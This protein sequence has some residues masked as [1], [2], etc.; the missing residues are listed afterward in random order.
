[1]LGVCYYPE[2]WPEARWSVDAAM[3]ADLGIRFVR[4]GEFS[5]SRLEP[6]RDHFDWSWLDR[7]LEA[8]NIA[9]LQVV[10]CTPTATPPKWLVD[11]RPDILAWGS[12]GQAK[13]FGS[14]RHYCFSSVAWRQETARI[15]LQMARRYGDHP[16][17][18]GWQLDNEYGCHDTVLSYAPH[19]R[20]AFQ[21]WLMRRYGVIEGLNKAWGGV[22]WS[23]EYNDFNQVGLPHQTVTEANPSHLLDFRR[24]SSDQVIA[25]NRMQ[26]EIIRQH[27][28]ERFVSH[29]AMGLFHDFDHAGL[30]RDLDVITWDSYPLGFTDQRMGLDRET[31]AGLAKTGHPDIAAFHHDLY[32]GTKEDGRFWVMEQ[33]PGP[34]NWADN[35]PIPA[36]NM[37][38]L[39]TLEALA[40]GAEVVS[41]FRWR[42][43]PFAQEQ[44]HAGLLRT[45]GEPAPV[46]AE[47]RKVREELGKLTLDSETTRP[48]KIA[49]IADDQSHWLLDIQRQGAGFD[50][51]KLNF[52][53]YKAC[54]RLGQ[55][56]DIVR[57]GADLSGYALAMMPCLPIISGAAE[58]ALGEFDGV[59]VV[60][61]RS[62]SKTRDMQIPE[63]LPPGI[64]QK[65]L[66]LKVIQVASLPPGIEE[67]LT[68]NEKAY[69]V[70][71]WQED[72]ESSLDATGHF[73]GGGGAIYRS[74][75]WHY[76]GFWPD[77]A[78]LMD[79]LEGL[80]IDLDIE[81]RRL[82]EQLRIRRRGNLAFAFNTGTKPEKA[83][84]PEGTSFLL[85]GA[86]IEPCG[87]AV[88]KT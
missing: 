54:R 19:C 82:P 73:A 68:W 61:P 1:M 69:P 25:Y 39:W 88:W 17:D 49:L 27:S 47:V 21:R 22:F 74:D 60:G 16:A 83:P 7:A 18:N 76:L 77:L 48:A 71:I 63:G 2:H 66:P 32:R 75:K 65:W 13:R 12:D 26:A 11:Q 46:F 86:D 24:F 14:R 55:D 45:D 38:R 28:P 84:A 20:L 43:A 53:F 4:I 78:F 51:K 10:L 70:D 8:L 35:N 81:V 64:L 87:V 31:R 44:M 40:H 67:A 37:V 85:G 59:M 5:W 52:N 3:M 36:K 80:L 58:E 33:Q 57:P 15:C 34:V 30:A 56:V 9:G 79:Y 29:N 23:Q 42:Q 50:L 6:S 41:Y 72:I 62:G